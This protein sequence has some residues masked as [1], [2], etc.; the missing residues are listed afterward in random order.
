M[1][2][3]QKKE[4]CLISFAEV[5]RGRNAA[6]VLNSEQAI[7]PECI[8]PPFQVILT[9]ASAL[10]YWKDIFC[11]SDGSSSAANPTQFV[12]LPLNHSLPGLF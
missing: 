12:Q 9:Y 11:R 7:K 2:L 5:K 6:W 10:E 4:T 3:S 1:S 8:N